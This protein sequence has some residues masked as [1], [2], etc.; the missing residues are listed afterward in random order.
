MTLKELAVK[1]AE[2]ET[3]LDALKEEIR[4]CKAIAA[5]AIDDEY[6]ERLDLAW[7]EFHE[8]SEAHAKQ[9]HA[10]LVAEAVARLPFPEGTILEEWSDT[11][12]MS[13]KWEYC[14]PS[15][16]GRVGS[17]RVIR[18][19]DDLKGIE[20]FSLY[21]GG[22]GVV[23]HKKDGTPGKLAVGY[24]RGYRWIEQGKGWDD[25]QPLKQPAQVEDE[26]DD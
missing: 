9:M 19:G 14:E 7:A 8:H 18:K 23:L 25:W 20:I 5:R 26:D 16:T 24:D 17:I 12:K 13:W 4:Q 10:E 3:K 15:K 2:A 11:K 21:V 22:I 6:S 1:S